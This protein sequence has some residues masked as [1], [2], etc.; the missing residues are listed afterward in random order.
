MKNIAIFVSGEGL[1]AERIVKLFNEGN[2][3]RTVLIVADDSAADGLAE[4]LKGEDVELLHI[5]DNEWREKSPMVA[6]LLKEKDVKLIVL[7]DFALALSDEIL[8][9]TDGEMIR[10]SGPDL[11]PREVVAALEADLRRPAEP[12]TP[13]K[14]EEVSHDEEEGQSLESEWAQS[15]K[16]NYTP[17]K[18]PTTPPEVPQQPQQPGSPE[19]KGFPQFG[20]RPKPNFG[21]K[22]EHHH[23]REHN[24]EKDEPMPSTYLI[25]SILVTIFCCFIPGIVAIIFS[26]QVSTRYMIGDFEG[27]RRASRLA[28]IWIIVSFVLGV[29][30]ATLYLP[31]MLVG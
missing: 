8:E 10:V 3:L 12:E 20:T 24:P 30:T 16:I 6:N 18:V 17:P 14:V 15:L 22:P 9:A 2:R 29:I 26:S 19:V 28:E 11:A 13:E 21:F 27:A 5:P 25:W 7:D 4:R 31:F 23:N 1:A